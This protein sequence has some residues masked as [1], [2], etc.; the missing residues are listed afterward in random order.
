MFVKFE[1]KHKKHPLKDKNFKLAIF[2]QNGHFEQLH[3]VILMAPNYTALLETPIY[4][5]HHVYFHQA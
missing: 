4:I 3:N 1:S 2:G 5:F